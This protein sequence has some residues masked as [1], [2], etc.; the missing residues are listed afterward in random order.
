MIIR[1]CD[2]IN[3]IG[4]K[5]RCKVKD[6]YITSNYNTFTECAEGHFIK[7][8]LERILRYYIFEFFVY[9]DSEILREVFG[10]KAAEFTEAF[11]KFINALRKVDEGND[12]S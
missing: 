9:S 2:C 11:D 7:G 1:C 12:H 5:M 6:H 10:K 3:W 4:D 8:L